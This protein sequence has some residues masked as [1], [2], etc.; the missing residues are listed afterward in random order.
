MTKGEEVRDLLVVHP[1]ESMWA[2]FKAPKWNTEKKTEKQD[3]KVK[4]YDEMFATLCDT[5]LSSHIDFDYGDE[6]ILSRWAKVSKK[7]GV[8]VL[9]VNKAKYKAVLVPPLYTIRS[10]TIKL[11]KKFKQ[12]GGQVVFV[13]KAPEYVDA[14]CSMQANDFAKSCENVSSFK[15]AI[16]RIEKTSRKISITDK[17]GKEINPALYLLRED[18]EAF[19]LFVCN[20]GMNWDNKDVFARSPLA[21]ER[22]IEFPEVI[23]KA[24]PEWKH[25]P[26]ELDPETGNICLANSI[27]TD[28]GYQ[29]K[30]D[31]GP[32]ASRL[33]IIP[34]SDTIQTVIARNMSSSCGGQGQ[35]ISFLTGKENLQE[36]DRFKIEKEIWEI[37]LSEPNICVLDRPFY[38]I[39]NGKWKQEEILRIDKTVRQHLSIKERGGAMVQPWAR[40]KNKN[41]RNAP[42]T[43]KYLFDIEKIPSGEISL[44]IE[45]PEFFK[46]KINGSKILAKLENGWWVD[47]SLKTLKFNSSILR[48]GRNEVLLECNYNEN[49]PGLEI[50]YILGDFGVKIKGKQ[51]IL[52]EPVGF[53]K[54]GDWTEQGLPF[55]SGNIGYTCKIIR[56]L[57][58]NQRIFVNI[59]DYRGAGIRILVD[60]KGAGV[61]GWQ[62]NQ[63]DITNYVRGKQEVVLTIEVLG[64]RRNSHGPLHLSEKW[65]IWTG[66]GSFVAEGKDWFE[67]YQT[68]PCGLMSRPEIIIKEKQI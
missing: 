32:I 57:K 10:S 65:P 42:V 47:K 23:I 22:L 50:V 46:I 20:T 7:N 26:I 44:A 56:D 14:V 48:A 11:L 16:T 64:H 9:I 66:P 17:E 31:L 51:V 6:E 13:D 59:S 61:I 45:K 53:L 18:K 49:H 28:T 12:T 19:Y 55:Y 21:R 2:I 58:E 35:A 43:L 36:V 34:K 67:G 5:L 30:T 1:I 41:P 63:L 4:E 3:T 39:G 62:P 37:K 40:K 8:P 27:K 33:F 24:V 38:K 60:G 54:I 15:E 25:Q 68:V 52:C 29:I